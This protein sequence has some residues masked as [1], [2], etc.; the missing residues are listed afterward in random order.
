MELLARAIHVARNVDELLVKC[1]I[2]G[3]KGLDMSKLVNVDVL[4]AYFI[5]CGHGHA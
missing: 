5:D 4:I 2:A 1:Q 3:L